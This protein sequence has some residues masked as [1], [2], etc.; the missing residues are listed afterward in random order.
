MSMPVDDALGVLVKGNRRKLDL[1]NKVRKQE[2]IEAIRGTGLWQRQT[3]HTEE[4]LK[5]C[6]LAINAADNPINVEAVVGPQLLMKVCE[7]DSESHHY[8]IIL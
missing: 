3:P 6:S 2:A 8:L 5:R 7:T 4:K 1:Q